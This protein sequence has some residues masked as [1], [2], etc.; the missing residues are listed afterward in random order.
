M[1]SLASTPD[2][3]V[4]SHATMTPATKVREPSAATL[5]RTYNTLHAKWGVLV[6][7]F[8]NH[9]P[10]LPNE[11]N[12]IGHFGG[13]NSIFAVEGAPFGSR[14]IDLAKSYFWEACCSGVLHIS[15]A[16]SVVI[17]GRTKTDGTYKHDQ[18]CCNYH[19]VG[20]C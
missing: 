14:R 13:T 7:S 2:P 1:W 3:M 10:S 18:T 19:L 8:P 6:D 11:G 4:A 9:L 12:S 16:R 5:V 20:T 17:P 15:D